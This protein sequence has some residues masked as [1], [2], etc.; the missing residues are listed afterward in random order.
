MRYEPVRRAVGMRPLSVEPAQSQGLPLSKEYVYAGGRLVA[1]E[2]PTPATTPTP[3]PGGPPPTALTA[4]GFFPSANSSGVKLVW[5]APSSGSPTSY[6]VER[7]SSRNQGGLL[8]GPVGS[9]VTTLPTQAN[10]YIDPSPAVGT[11]YVYRVKAMYAGGPSDYSN[12]DLATTVRY[13]GDDPLVGGASVIRAADLSELRA[14]VEAVRSLAGVG[15]GAWKS[16]PAPAFGGSILKEHYAELRTNLDPALD[17]LGIGRVPVDASIALTLPV[18]AVHIQ[19]VRDK[20][21]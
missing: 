7:A 5:A 15:A 12:Q 8:Y 11:V 14:V 21:R 2:E 10:P 3:T 9:P 4:T 19:D 1:T 18:K 17:E 13:S 20:V 6:V 16:N